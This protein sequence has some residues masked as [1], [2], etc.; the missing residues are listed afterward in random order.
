MHQGPRDGI[1]I[2]NRL[3]SGDQCSQSDLAA[4]TRPGSSCYVR[5]DVLIESKVRSDG[6]YVAISTV[7]PWLKKLS[8]GAT[9]HRSFGFRF[10]AVSF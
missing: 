5:T 9:T 4:G 1:A 3:G 7:L 10:L 6:L 8:I 2:C